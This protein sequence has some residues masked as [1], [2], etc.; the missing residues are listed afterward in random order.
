M[1]L[2][3]SY[4]ACP[5]D[6]LPSTS[7]ETFICDGYPNGPEAKGRGA[8]AFKLKTTWDRD[9]LARE[10]EAWER[11]HKGNPDSSSHIVDYQR[12][13]EE[14]VS[15]GPHVFGGKPCFALVMEK[16]EHSLHQALKTGS[17]RGGSLLKKIGVIEELTKAVAA[18][19]QAGM[20]WLDAKPAVGEVPATAIVER[21]E[22]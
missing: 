4:Y 13:T 16:G 12:V 18:I 8:K 21:G 3:R 15:L 22:D 7:N 14:A 2:D 20:V 1:L 17:F 6:G 9:L 10:M 11:I 5:C 19:N